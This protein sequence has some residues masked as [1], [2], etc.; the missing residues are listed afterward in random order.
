MMA[1]PSKSELSSAGAILASSSATPAQKS[2][3]GSTLGKG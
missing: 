3:A 1:K 2:K